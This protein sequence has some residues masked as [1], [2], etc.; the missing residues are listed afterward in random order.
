MTSDIAAE[1]GL[2]R[3]I[4]CGS[5]DDGKS[6]LMG[7]L[8]YESGVLAQDH[9]ESLTAESARR[10]GQDGTIDFS[11]LFDGLE[12][13]REQGITID[14]AYRY[15]TTAH[16]SFIV[17]DAPGHEQYTANMVTGAST[18]DLA[19]VL[20][21]AARGIVDQTRRHACLVALLGVRQVVL[22]VTKM[23]LVGWDRE[24]FQSIEAEFRDFADLIGLTRV[25]AIPLSGIQ[26]DNVVRASGAMPWYGGPTLL[27][28]LETVDLDQ[29][30]AAQQPFRMPVQWVSR[31]DNVRGYAGQIAAGTIKPGDRVVC[32]PSGRTTTVQRIVEF[33]GDRDAASA[34]TSTTLVLADEIDC[35]RGDVLSAAAQP[36]EIADQFEVTLFWMSRSDLI[37]GRSYWLRLGPT[38]VSAQVTDIKHRLD[39]NTLDRLAAKT[40]EMNEIGVC[41][42]SVDRDIA[43]AAYAENR[44][45]GGF[46]LIDRLT[47]ATVGAGAI[48]FA[49]TR[50]HTIRWQH[51]DIS[52]E[53]RAQ[54]LGQRPAVIWFTGLSGSGKST[55]ANKLE[56]R[57]HAEGRHT[58]I[59]DGDNIR[60]GLSHDL[61]FTEVDRVEN[62]RRV[63]EVARLMAD[64]GLIVMVSLISPFRADREMAR[65]RIE[66][67]E[68]IEVFVDVPL[69]V[70][71]ERDPKGLYLRA[72]SGEIANFTGIDSPYEP[73]KDPEVYIDTLAV[74][75][76]DGVASIIDTLKARGVLR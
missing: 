39:V 10:T 27:A 20:V 2:L 62:I 46:I 4:T 35:S 19:V 36:A 57:L 12:A 50:S 42:L 53:T 47:N 55:L 9:L 70:A 28:H 65:D 44:E 32:Q 15:F 8:L 31:A 11:L 74:T 67:G 58:Y 73:P 45:L 75:V 18:A 69:Q 52:R 30:A 43:F 72:R 66:A 68:F 6:T 5:V 61:G 7:R 54:A 48:Q 23:D 22:A 33:E 29:T 51:L 1:P 34:G 3:F 76:E 13:E 63:A 26:G 37:V 60:H 24:R 38:L 59:L 40:L 17:A 41:N 56:S 16:R 14:V 64:A 71:E 25:V 49:L 21:D